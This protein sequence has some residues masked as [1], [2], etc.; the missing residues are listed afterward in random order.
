MKNFISLILIII[1]L[2]IT[3]QTAR[4]AVISGCQDG[5][6]YAI[7]L[8]PAE[9]NLSEERAKLIASEAADIWNQAIGRTVI[10]YNPD[11]DFLV[12]FVFDERQQGTINRLLSERGL[13]SDR[14][15]LEESASYVEGL[16]QQFS[17]AE[18][19]Y[20]SNRNKYQSAQQDFNDQVQS[21]AVSS[22]KLAKQRA[23]LEQQYQELEDARINLNNLASSLNL[24][25]EQANRL[26]EL[27]NEKVLSFNGAFEGGEV[28]RQGVYNGS[29]IEVYQY[30]NDEDL[31]AL[32]VHEFGHALGIDHVSDPMAVM[33]Y[34]QHEDQKLRV[35]LTEADTQ[36]MIN[37]CQETWWSRIDLR[38]LIN[39]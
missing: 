9:F 20:N 29:A 25:T 39:I 26:V 38:E 16:K 23:K 33:Y 21:G 10:S 4:S 19:I 37:V 22:D 18:I 36:A 2:G 28:F 6:E 7:N 8:V 5:F 17:Q 31:R 12:D 30:E 11:S 13:D 35:D 27:Y 32:L 14:I 24:A 1:A 3:Y 34:L 15:E